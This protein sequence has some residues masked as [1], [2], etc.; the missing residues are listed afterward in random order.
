MTAIYRL[1]NCC[2]GLCWVLSC[3]TQVRKPTR[4]NC[5]KLVEETVGYTHIEKVMHN[6]MYDLGWLRWAGIEVQGKII[7]TMI[8][9]PL[10]NEHR[11]YYNLNSLSGEYLGEWKNEK[12]LRSAADM[13]GVDP[14]LRCGSWTHICGQVRRTRCVC[15]LTSVG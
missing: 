6:C 13:Y 11:R 9:A 5:G 2:W 4:K 3:K 15:H 7:D 1:C 8:A 12:M 10:L 14:K